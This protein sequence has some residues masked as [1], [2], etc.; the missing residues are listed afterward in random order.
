M[1]RRIIRRKTTRKIVDFLNQSLRVLR[2]APLAILILFIRLGDGI[3]LL[4]SIRARQGRIRITSPEADPETFVA[5]TL[6]ALALIE[7]HDAR[8]YALL[9][10]EFFFITDAAFDGRGE[11]RRRFRECRI[12]LDRFR[13]DWNE[14]NAPQHT[15]KYAWFLARYAMTLIHEAT[16]GRLYSLGFAYSKRTRLRCERICVAEERRFAAHL[17]QIHYNFDRDLVRP[18]DATWWETY[19]NTSA[20]Q[21]GA[22]DRQRVNERRLNRRM[23]GN[24]ND[25]ALDTPKKK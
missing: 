8:R 21:R 11:Y 15:E 18:F 3:V 9:Q 4:R 14:R 23:S 20:R 2:F 10:K 25:T 1:H 6:E 5:V 7:K 12:N 24:E 16:H 22:N 19:W 13:F 17:P